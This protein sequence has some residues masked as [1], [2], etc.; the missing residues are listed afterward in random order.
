LIPFVESVHKNDQIVFWPDLASAH[1]SNMTQGFRA[2]NN[3]EYVPKVHNPANVPE[4]R[5]IEE[6][7]SEIKRLVYENNW[8]AENIKQL[9]NRIRY[10]FNKVD[11][12]G[13]AKLLLLEWTEFV[14]IECKTYNFFLILFAKH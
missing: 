14:D 12:I 7:W 10:A 9:A 11:I 8:Q 6:F 4:L 13:L 3:I 1:Y 2:S 5:P